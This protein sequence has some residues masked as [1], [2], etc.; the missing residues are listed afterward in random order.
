VALGLTEVTVGVDAVTTLTE[1][2]AVT[3]VSD[4]DVAVTMTVLGEGTV[5]GA[6][7]TPVVE[8][9]VPMPV[10]VVER[11]QVTLSQVWFEVVLHPGLFTVAVKRKVSPVPTVA[12]VGVIVMLIPV[13]MVRVA[14]AV[15]LVSACA[16][17]VT[18][19]V[20]AIV[21]VP[22][23]VTVGIVAGAV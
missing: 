10:N 7:Y 19:T 2:V 22:L 9:I 16:V 6:E 23:D 1:A 15:F 4:T 20:G 5:A 12:L 3:E 17:A 18:V 14:V 21:V 8:P 11:D 13:M